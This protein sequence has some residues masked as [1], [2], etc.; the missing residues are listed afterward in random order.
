MS[1]EM[2]LLLLV[3]LTMQSVGKAV[4]D[5]EVVGAAA[6]D[7][8]GVVS[9][10]T[11]VAE[12]QGQ[13][14]AGND[15]GGTDE[16][17]SVVTAAAG[18]IGISSVKRAI[19][20]AAV[21]VIMA[22][23]GIIGVAAGAVGIDAEDAGSVAKSGSIVGIA[24][25]GGVG[26]AG[27]GGTDRADVVARPAFAVAV[28]DVGVSSISV[29]GAGIDDGAGGIVTCD[30][31]SVGVEHAGGVGKASGIAVAIAGNV[32]NVGGLVVAV[33][34]IVSSMIFNV[35]V[36]G[37]VRGHEVRGKEASVGRSV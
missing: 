8:V 9:N 17:I 21:S 15:A 26:I 13:Q 37:Q 28:G 25:G 12:T 29:E 10:P 4:G 31:V 33:V 36:P 34:V 16:A 7:D 11:A 23:S 19:V 22:G 1:S 6:A 14:G 20:T 32:V 35:D 3:A 30:A 27:A 2:L 24:S 5:S 18:D